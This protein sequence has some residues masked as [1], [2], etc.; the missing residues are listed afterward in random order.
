MF[1]AVRKTDVSLEVAKTDLQFKF[2]AP[3]AGRSGN[4]A[5]VPHECKFNSTE[6]SSAFASFLTLQP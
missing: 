5:E 4:S 2:C 6:L 3:I 1:E